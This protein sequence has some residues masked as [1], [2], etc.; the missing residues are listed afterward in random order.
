[1]AE[2]MP[3]RRLLRK[4]WRVA[5]VFFR[6]DRKRKAYW[7]LSIVL[8]L[9]AICAGVMVSISYIQRD[10]STAVSNKDVAGFHKALWKFI[11]VVVVAT[12]LLA[13]Y[14]YSQE[15]L[16]VE[17]RVW[18]SNLLLTSYFTNRAYF[19]LKMEGKVDNPDQRICEDVS[20][21]VLNAVDILAI[22]ASKCLNVCAF[23]GV[24]WFIAPELVYFL[25][26]YSIV[27]TYVTVRFFGA[28]IMH[29]KYQNLQKE[30][31]FRYSMVRVR[32]NAES[33]AFYRGEG[34]EVASV[35]AFLASL[36]GNMREL[37]VWDRHLSLFSNAYEFSIFIVPY[38]IIAPKFFSGQVE[39]GVIS[40]TAMAFHKILT[41]MSFIILKFDRFSGLAAQTERLDTLFI[42][43]GIHDQL[44]GSYRRQSSKRAIQLHVEDDTD[45][46]P[47]LN[48]TDSQAPISGSITREEGEGLVVRGLSVT[49]PNLRTQLIHN[50]SF[51]LLP[52][53]SLLVLGPSG[54]GKSSFLRVIAGLWS[55]GAGI[56]QVPLQKTIFLPQKPYMP[57]GTLRQQLLFP[58][59]SS[60]YFSDAEL[61]KVLEEVSLED[62]IQ[63][64]GGLDSVCD[65]SDVLSSGE[66]QRVAFARL[67][68]HEPQMAFLDE[69]TS[70]LDMTNESKLYALLQ[71][72]I[73]SYVSVGHRISLIKY[74][75]RVLEFKG[76]SGWKLYTQ[77][78]FQVHI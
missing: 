56:I 51:E 52:G 65:W 49:T 61:F 64:V 4:V 71:R 75:S 15:L 45:G 1:M 60:E 78:E 5:A 10:L 34:H 23:T 77:K 44:F 40:Q 9:C 7:L 50:L 14:K 63:R 21:F 46:H 33:I 69:A 72:K 67:L 76:S 53:E 32:E 38:L 20:N 6:G 37:I 30:A 73:K 3:S 55:K 8:L 48:L 29:L 57:L 39:F 26:A 11:G 68:L 22:I 41:S 35:K 36:V 12:P 62:L 2:A 25:L 42:A 28:K 19:D 54:C 31:D 24:L 13:F 66:Q 70:A 16:A 74:H 18:L 43:L 58:A 17:W 59:L 27:G 47:L